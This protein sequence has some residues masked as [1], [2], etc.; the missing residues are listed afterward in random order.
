MKTDVITLERDFPH[1]ADRVWRAL[2]QPD[3]LAKWL[4]QT[5]FAAEEGRAFRFTADWGQVDC[6]V[7]EIEPGRKL[8]YTW[9]S[10]AL[11]TVVTWTLTP[12][13]GGTRL[14]LEQSGFT[15]D[16]PPEYLKGA[17]AGW[18]RFLDRLGALLD[19]TD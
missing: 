8:S 16:L 9:G 18:P 14:T 3:L 5:D 1:P 17:K 6:T 4:M 12:T 13:S 15:P 11:D 2:T 7:R 19:Q 10:G